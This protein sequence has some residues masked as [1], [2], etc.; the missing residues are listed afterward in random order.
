MSERFGPYRL[1]ERIEARDGAERF[2]ATDAAGQNVMLTRYSTAVSQP[3][4]FRMELDEARIALDLDH[5]NL[6]KTL[7]I[8]IIEER[9]CVVHEHVDGLR[10]ETLMR[11][12]LAL[13]KQVSPAAT[14]DLMTQLASALQYLHSRTAHDGSTLSW[15]HRNVM[16][17]HILV[18]REGCVRLGGLERL[19]PSGETGS[20]MRYF[21]PEQVRARP[22][23]FRSDLFSL[24]VVGW[25]LLTGRALFR[26]ENAFAVLE[27]VMREVIPHPRTI[28]S[29]LP[30][31][32]CEWVM[33]LLQRDPEDRPAS[34]HSALSLTRDPG[35]LA[36]LVRFAEAPNAQPAAVLLVEPEEALRKKGTRALERKGYSVLS[37]ASVE[38]SLREARYLPRRI[39]LVVA[40][41]VR[42]RVPGEVPRL[43]LERPYS[44]EN[45]VRR[46]S[47]RLN[48]GAQVHVG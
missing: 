1:H 11:R 30:V 6:V 47:E 33:S 40:S 34:T 48:P 37:G 18:D 38:G 20:P 13:H 22:V 21:S 23:D 42:G 46:V 9:G 36:N 39:G 24:G 15:V 43:R 44:V 14:A 25:E 28:D 27:A 8:A 32:L 29:R 45:L 17:R 35:V 4:Y 12:L 2:L 16:P 10:L 7:E 41:G 31:G 26:G 5:P 19:R 3:T